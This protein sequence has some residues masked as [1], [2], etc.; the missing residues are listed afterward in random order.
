MAKK[1]IPP[2][3]F[4]FYF[5]LGPERSYRAVA[6]HFGVSKTAVANL[7]ERERW[8]NRVWELEKQAHDAVEKK[9][10][11]TLEQMSERHLKMLKLIQRKAL[12]T[13]K[14][15]PL[16]TAVEAAKTLDAS[17]KTER[18]VRGEPTDRSMLSVEDIIRK[19]YERWMTTAESE[20]DKDVES[21]EDENALDTDI[22]P[23]E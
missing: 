10:T 8:Q 13:L 18:L 23:T 2:D 9:M 17:I 4:H 22:A 14:S 15:M 7:A 11:E 16:S 20:E 12:E 21:E 6:E 5:A 19:E 1:K 3:A